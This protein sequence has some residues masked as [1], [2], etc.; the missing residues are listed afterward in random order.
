ML[1]NVTFRDGLFGLQKAFLDWTMLDIAM[2]VVMSAGESVDKTMSRALELEKGYDWV[3]SVELYRAVLGMVP[4][5]D[6][7]RAGEVHERVGYCWFR[8]AMQADSVDEFKKRMRLS[9]EAYEK[10]AELFEKAASVK[11]LYCR[12]AASY[13]E[14]WVV[15]DPSRKKELYDD[16]WRLMKEALEGFD[17]SGD[18]L[19]L[20]KVFRISELCICDVSQF[21]DDWRERERICEEI[22]NY[23]QRFVA[24]FSQTANVDL[25]VW[26]CTMAS[27][28]ILV[29]ADLFEERREELVSKASD[30]L[31][32]ASELQENIEDD[33]LHF[34]LNSELV[35]A[36]LGLWVD[37]RAASEYAEKIMRR[38]ERSN[39]HFLL[40][41]AYF[42]LSSIAYGEVL[43][44]ED[45]DKSKE[46]CRMAI[47]FNEESARHHLLV[48]RYDYAP[49][50]L[51]W[52]EEFY[53][54]LAYVETTIE[55]KRGLLKQ[56]IEVGRKGYEYAQ[57][58]GSPWAIGA[59]LHSF[60]KAFYFLSTTE[61]NIREKK[62]LL[63]EA[64]ELREKYISLC[65]R[66]VP[67]YAWLRGIGE[68]YLALIKADLAKTEEDEAKERQLLEEAISGMEECLQICTK[69]LQIFY[70]KPGQSDFAALG[71]Y[72]D[73]FGNILNQTYSLTK[74]EKIIDR[75]L[76]VYQDTAKVYQ[77]AGM[78]SR[79][80]EAYWKAAKLYDRRGE[81]VK[82]ADNFEQASKNYQLVAEKIPQFKCFYEDHKSY[83]QAWSEFE[84]AKQA[85]QKEQ[86]QQSKTHYENAAN[87]L[88]PTKRWDY[89]AP[90][91]TAWATLEQAEDLS[92]QEKSDEARQAFQQAA[93][94][95]V[96]AKTSLQDEAKNIEDEDEKAKTLELS[97]TSELRRDYCLARAE[98]EEAKIHDKDEDHEAS[99]RKYS[100]VAQRFEK[101]AEKL[102]R[103]VDR[104]ELLFQ[105]QLCHALGKMELAHEKADA[106]L[107]AEA[108]ELFTKT[109]KITTTKRNSLLALGNACFCKALESGTK[110]KITPNPDLYTTAKQYM[111]RAA[112]H[113]TE[114]GFENA[115][116]WT[117]ATERFFDAYFYMCNAESEMDPETKAK[118]YQLAER[119][120][121]LAARLYETAGYITKRNETLRHLERVREEKELFITPTEI[122]K[123][124]TIVSAT[125]TISAPT[126]TKEEA[127]GLEGLEHANIQANLIIRIKEVKVGEDIN[128]E[129]EL[130]N[131]GKAPA[132]LIKT[133]KLI[134]EGF[135]IIQK[136]EIYRVEDS[137][138]NMKGKRL[139]PLKTEEV[140]LVL[141]ALNKGTFTLKPKI[142]YLDE[143][144]KY[145]SHEPEPTT[146]KV[147]EL[148][149]SGW[150]KG[151]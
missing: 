56:A 101:I 24:K 95:F 70:E 73:W 104:N 51:S 129:L 106:D 7:L 31:K 88:K 125:P 93:D 32:K 103:E 50:S 113:Y 68:N 80:A 119:H 143:T 1:L 43:A 71:W 107:Y 28:F 13:S 47:R 130:V 96:E 15:E 85:H 141:K 117:K 36:N 108:S 151:Q 131:A 114:A 12:G 55:G 89:L 6:V 37:L 79:V 110:F 53:F 72:H 23:G 97:E 60:S 33:Y 84:K 99:A 62:K 67:P 8:A 16:C 140:K 83:M 111:E 123:A 34:F 137:Y 82:A 92:K 20:E 112:H 54:I 49:Q 22:M 26:A 98:L 128:L 77:K 25:L 52:S 64:L 132:L 30:Y 4:A 90:N 118:H 126:P 74:D 146:I 21:L 14:S 27:F 87:L 142:L 63:K 121:D 66:L 59:L 86:Y 135:E 69:Y 105:A 29:G 144:G 9:V 138:L 75:A 10:A 35:Y 81:F 2:V 148:G 39:D 102:E 5:E 134:P 61:T 127:V 46:K 19:G 100:E 18:Y 116:K 57:L 109:Q 150:L 3:G 147:K 133:D 48:C 122:L 136:P 40:G 94:Q 149:I 78:P 91:F 44:E 42:M 65:N 17:A 38:G 124:P 145:R 45:P 11:G 120:L 76:E 139:D 58:S 41:Q 115:S